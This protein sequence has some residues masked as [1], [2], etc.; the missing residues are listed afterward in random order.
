[1]SCTSSTDTYGGCE[2]HPHFEA[3]LKRTMSH[4]TILVPI[5]CLM[6]FGHLNDKREVAEGGRVLSS[7]GSRIVLTPLMTVQYSRLLYED[8]VLLIISLC[9]LVPSFGREESVQYGE[10]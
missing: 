9:A 5:F 2:G 3:I 1:M 4:R 10:Q 8:R 7:L 6:I